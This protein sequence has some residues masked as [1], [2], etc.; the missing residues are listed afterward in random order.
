[1][2]GIK[3]VVVSLRGEIGMPIYLIG[4]NPQFAIQEVSDMHL[5]VQRTPKNHSLT[6]MEIDFQSRHGFKAK[7]DELEIG[8]A[9][10]VLLN[11]NDSIISVLKV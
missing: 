9:E 11:K 6:L 4:I 1:M 10:I 7:K 8:Q 3:S 2:I 5:L